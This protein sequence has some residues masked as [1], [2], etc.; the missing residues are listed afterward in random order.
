MHGYDVWFDSAW[1]VRHLPPKIPSHAARFMQDVYRW[2]YEVEKL[3]VANSIKGM[4]QVRPE[5]LRPYPVGVDIAWRAHQDRA[6]VAAPRHRG[7]RSAW[8]TSRSGCSGRHVAQQWARRV[9]S[10]YFSFQTYWPQVMSSLWGDASLA[11]QMVKMGT[12][13]WHGW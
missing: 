1:R 13:G 3:A 4:R 8:T 9:A 10:S 6:H 2:N 5:S 12:A 7:A 11:E